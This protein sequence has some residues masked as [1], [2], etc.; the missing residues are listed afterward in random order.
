ML[1]VVFYYKPIDRFSDGILG[2]KLGCIILPAQ[3]CCFV[4][5]LLAHS[6]G[7]SVFGTWEID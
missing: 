1:V 5:S 6:S 2:A 3:I 7:I 4:L